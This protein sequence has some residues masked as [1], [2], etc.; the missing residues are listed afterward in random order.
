MAPTLW[1]PGF[2]L[3]AGANVTGVEVTV[4]RNASGGGIQDSD[5]R[6]VGFFPGPFESNSLAIPG[7]WTTTGPSA[8]TYGGPSSLF[9]LTLDADEVNHPDFGFHIA[10]QNTSGAT[11]D[12]QVDAVEVTIYYWE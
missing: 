11:A 12:A 1:L 3:P 10:A 8:F 2:A 5:A 9:G 4:W 6:V 7:D